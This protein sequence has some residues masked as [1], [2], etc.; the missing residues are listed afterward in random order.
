MC[1]RLLVVLLQSLHS[2]SMLEK[3]ISS[4]IKFEKSFRFFKIQ[5]QPT[6]QQM[7]EHSNGR[8][9]A[10]SKSFLKLWKQEPEWWESERERNKMSYE[11]ETVGGEPPPHPC[12][13]PTPAPFSLRRVSQLLVQWIHV[14]HF[15]ITT[16]GRAR[17]WGSGGNERRSST[18]WSQQQHQRYQ[19]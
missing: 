18:S 4:K 8:K 15:N 1:L 13:H 9:V 3:S 14:A 10:K 19:Q 6:N 7:R 12:P 5:T 11:G 2:G 16:K 17:S